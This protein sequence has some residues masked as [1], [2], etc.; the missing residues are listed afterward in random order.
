M[1]RQEAIEVIKKNHPHVA[2]SGSQFE[3]AIRELVPELAE[4]EDER[5]RKVLIHIVKGACDKYGIKYRGNEITEEKLL[6]YLEKQKE[7]HSLVDAIVPGKPY[8]PPISRPTIA[9]EQKLASISCGHENDSNHAE[10]S[11]EDEAIINKMRE[12]YLRMIG[13]RPDISPNQEWSASIQFIDKL[14]SLRPQP[15]PD[16]SACAKHLEGY[17]SGRADAE[18]ELLEKYGMIITPDDEIRIKPQPHW[19]PSKEQVSILAKVFAG[20]ELNT[21]EKDSMVDLLNH[22]KD[23]I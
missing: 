2:T 10:W 8:F 6:A 21:P 16:C 18:K 9:E 20:C 3:T 7:S 22:L 17:I 14:K 13:D 5:V 11:E 4:S 23:M 19:K 1:N 15:K 12:H